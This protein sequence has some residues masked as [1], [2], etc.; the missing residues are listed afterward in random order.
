MSDEFFRRHV[1]ELLSVTAFRD[2]HPGF[3]VRLFPLDELADVVVGELEGRD[4]RLYNK[5]LAALLRG[6]QVQRITVDIIDNEAT[7][8]DGAPVLQAARDAGATELWARVRYTSIEIVE[9]SGEAAIR[10]TIVLGT[11][12]S[13]SD[14]QRRYIDELISD[15]AFRAR[16][17]N[18]HV[19]LFPIDELAHVYV[20]E[21]QG[22]ALRLYNKTLAALL[23]GDQ[24][25]RLI[26]ELS[27][28]S[29]TPTLAAGEPILQA[30]RDAGATE[31]MARVRYVSREVVPVWWRSSHEPTLEVITTD[32]D[33]AILTDDDIE[34]ME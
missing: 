14:F 4:L 20:Q 2:R 3:Q 18:F 17:P 15:P 34:L 13:A 7:L 10:D 29:G 30:A 9:S 31:I 5:S 32:D 21:L 19:R 25:E 6:D 23:R 26:V 22:S 28:E 16:H 24:T 1:D 12:E 11:P 33:D 27:D 8:A